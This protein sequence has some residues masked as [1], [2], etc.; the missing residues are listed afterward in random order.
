MVSTTDGRWQ[1]NSLAID[2]LELDHPN[3]TH[4]REPAHT[5]ST[6]S[7]VELHV[8]GLDLS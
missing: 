5:R 4:E 8:D 2:T 6:G 3:R 1:R 7:V